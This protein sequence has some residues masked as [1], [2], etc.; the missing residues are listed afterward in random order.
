MTYQQYTH[1]IKLCLYLGKE[2]QGEFK[3][4]YDFTTCLWKDMEFTVVDE[5]NKQGIIFHKG[6]EFYMEQDFKNGWFECNYD[7]VWS[8]FRTKKDMKVP[9][10][11]DFILSAVEEHLKCQT[12]T[13]LNIFSL[14]Q[15]LVEEH[16]KHKLETPPP[17]PMNYL[18]NK[19]KQWWKNISRIQNS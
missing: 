16:L 11:Q 5:H 17:T 19:L 18:C 9:E 12:P 10:I 14:P 3:E 15:F 6:D 2:P 13:P 8:F 4:Y 1:H 7:R